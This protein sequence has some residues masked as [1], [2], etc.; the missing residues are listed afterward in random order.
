MRGR[1]PAH[2]L[3][4]AAAVAAAGCRRPAEPQPAARPSRAEGALLSAAAF[5]RLDPAARAAWEGY[6]ARSARQRAADTA[7]M[8]AEL[9]ASGLAAMRRAPYARGFEVTDSM[10]AAWFAGDSARLLGER[11]L[12]FQAPNGGW[13]KHVD[14]ARARQP[15]E[16]YFGES[17]S[18]SWISTI[19]NGST[20]EQLRFLAALQ[21]AQPAARWHAAFER[22][23]GYL[24]AAQYPNGCWPQVWPLQGSYHDAITFNDDATVRAATVLREVGAG[25]MPFAADTLRALAKRAAERAAD[26]MLATQVV[27]GGRRTGWGQ[28]HHPL[29]LEP[30]RARSY[31]HESVSSQETAAILR[32]LMGVER[33]SPV[34]AG[35][36]HDGFAWLQRVALRDIAYDFRTGLR[37][38]PGEGPVWARMYELGTDRPIFSNRDGVRRYDWNELTD[39]RQG[40]GWYSYTPVNALRHYERWR[41]R[42]PLPG[43]DSTGRN[44]R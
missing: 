2:A 10:T 40:Y 19:D 25:A 29:T 14:Y 4:L 18:W 7:A 36:V 34:L 43:A 44:V 13:S 31:E 35:A 20:T 42:N 32:F 16:S 38:A 9:R 21:A 15:G 37:A 12:T 39:R 41:R 6:L 33:P 24:L 11:M 27:Q 3:I 26:C 1:G 8:N 23:V 30:V 28:Q 22:G 17:D 5:A